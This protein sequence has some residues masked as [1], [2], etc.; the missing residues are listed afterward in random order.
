MTGT[1]IMMTGWLLPLLVT[2]AMSEDFIFATKFIPEP[3]AVFSSQE[4]M[5]DKFSVPPVI[6]GE[7]NDACWSGAAKIGDFG[8]ARST[9]PLKEQTEVLLGYDAKYLYAAFIC[10]ASRPDLLRKACKPSAPEES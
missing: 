2:S 1:K 4:V 5:I 8:E 6:D 3:E 10:H 7:L 9:A